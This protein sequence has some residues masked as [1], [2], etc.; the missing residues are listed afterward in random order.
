[1]FKLKRS[2]SSRTRSNADQ[3]EATEAAL[4]ILIVSKVKNGLLV[5]FTWFH[6]QQPHT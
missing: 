3:P 1:M 6:L 5:P 4:T 2:V